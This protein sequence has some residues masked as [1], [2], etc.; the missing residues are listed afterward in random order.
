[1]VPMETKYHNEIEVERLW[2]TTALGKSVLLLMPFS[3]LIVFGL[4]NTE[5]HAQLLAWFAFSSFTH[6]FRW[7]ILH[8]YRSRKHRLAANVNRYK[9]LVL[10]A[11]MVTSAS[12]VLSAVLFLDVNDPAN[13]LFICL[14]PIIQAVGAMMTWFA[15]FPAV[16]MLSIPNGLII[17]FLLLHDGGERFLAAAIT[18]LILPMLSYYYTQKF[19]SMLNHVLEL[20]FEN[21]TLRQE[22]EE[23]S[24]QLETALENMGQGIAMSDKHD[25]LRMWNKHFS[26]LLASTDSRVHA[27]AQLTQLLSSATPP[28]PT[29]TEGTTQYRLAD[30]R[31]Y[32]I[33]QVPLTHGGRV[34]TFT[35]ISNLIK[36]ETALENARKEAVRANAAKTRFL[37]S[38][39]HDLRQPIHA[40]GLFFGELSER[41]RDRDTAQLIAQV[42]DSIA[43]INSMLNALLDVSKLDAGVVKPEF[44]PCL[45]ADIFAR[46]Q[47][48]FQPLAQENLNAVRFRPCRYW[49]ET[50]PA[51]LERMLRNLIGNALRYTENGRV[52]VGARLRGTQVEIQVIDTGHGIPPDQLKE[53]FVEFHQLHN[54]GRNRQQGLGLG[55]AIVKRLGSLLHHRVA[56]QSSVGRGSCFSINIPLAVKHSPVD[57]AHETRPAP[58]TAALQ[59]KRILLLDDDDSVLASMSGLLARW[60]CKVQSAR[61]HEEAMR[62]LADYREG[63]DLLVSD[64]RLADDV[65]GVE[66]ARDML[67]RFGY[68]FAVL[69]ITG[70]TD[71]ER[72]REAEASGFPLLH[73]PVH[74][75]KLRATLQHLLGNAKPI[76]I[77][78]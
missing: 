7:S 51:M 36:R 73:K 34:I 50:D 75:A 6:L 76:A 15:Y 26:Q 12:W 46:L 48:E 45:L 17:T 61:S 16:L 33:R 32:E 67:H 42:D 30:G 3:L 60:G 68:R 11:E 41:V 77:Y 8:Y 56:V 20:S 23:K 29:S 18:I 66:V 22:S 5:P 39:S 13:V 49:V 58:P 37:A 69:V 44:R 10:L 55:L 52:L 72:L 40:L 1:M 25:G 14:P 19:S 59:N 21:A 53:V 28:V 24:D 71:P 78:P 62:Q 47:A 9:T 4:W 64:Y 65:T 57:M 54:P 31:V 43:A 35:D 63:F 27:N 38:A 70:D 74:P 2:V